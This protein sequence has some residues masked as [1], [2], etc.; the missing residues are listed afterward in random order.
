MRIVE[1]F[2]ANHDLDMALANEFIGYVVIPGFLCAY[3]LNALFYHPEYV[4]EAFENPSTLFSRFFGLSSY[5]GFIGAVLG[6]LVWKRKRGESLL[7]YGDA[8]SFALVFGWLFGRTGCFVVHDHPGAI[9]DFPLAVA[10]YQVGAPPF[11]PRHDLGFYEV[12]W[13]L[14]VAALLWKLGQKRRPRGFFL[15]LV[16]MLYTPVRFLLDFLRATDI[17][18][19]DR[20]Y[21]GLTP[22]QYASVVFFIISAFLLVRLLRSEQNVE[23][24]APEEA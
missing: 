7:A 10:D 12:I 6:A 1:W 4:L 22:A 18:A 13:S 23:P 20:R 9:T 21:A 19:A 11:M 14:V 3:F 24:S 5:G 15:M 17:G 8:T 16:P 2:A